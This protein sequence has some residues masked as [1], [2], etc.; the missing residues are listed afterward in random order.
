[1]TAGSEFIRLEREHQQRQSF[2]NGHVSE[3][4]APD[5]ENRLSAKTSVK[6]IMQLFVKF[7]AGIILGSWSESNR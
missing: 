3:T 6:S 5:I 1:M 7:S 4:L 2:S